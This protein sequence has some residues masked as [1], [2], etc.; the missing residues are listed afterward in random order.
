MLFFH[1]IVPLS[2]T[3]TY[4]FC[5]V[6]VEL[7][8]F[9]QDADSDGIEALVQVDSDIYD[10]VVFQVQRVCV[11][12]LG[13]H[14]VVV[15]DS[16]LDTHVFIHLLFNFIEQEDQWLAREVLGAQAADQ[17]HPVYGSVISN[18]GD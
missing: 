11:E 10:Q 12:A 17:Q 7:G 13:S 18:C 3:T 2:V 8:N 1:E 16:L 4:Q 9:P 5:W 6:E 15:H 14:F